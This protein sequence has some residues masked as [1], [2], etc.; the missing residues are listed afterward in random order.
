MHFSATKTAIFI[1]GASFF[2]LW[3]AS[4]SSRNAL[5]PIPSFA[6]SRRRETAIRDAR[7]IFRR[8]TPSGNDTTYWAISC[9]YPVSGIYT[10]F[11]RILFYVAM[12]FTFC[13]SVHEWLTASGMALIVTYSTTAA[14]HGVVLSFQQNVGTDLDYFAIQA[15]L[16][17]GVI[18]GAAFALF[19]PQSL[20]TDPKL[21]YKAWSVFLVTASLCMMVTYPK[22]AKQLGESAVMAACDVDWNCNDTCPLHGVP[23][24]NV[25][26][27][28]P[29]D[30][31]VP[32]SFGPW[33]MDDKTTINN[34]TIITSSSSVNIGTSIASTS[35]STF[36]HVVAISAGCALVL[37]TT[38]VNLEYPPRQ[39]RNR[40]VKLLTSKRTAKSCGFSR[41][42]FIAA[43]AIVAVLYIWKAIVWLV[44]PLV[45]VDFLFYMI[46]IWWD[47]KRTRRQWIFRNFPTRNE[48][49]KFRLRLA[50]GTSLA[51][52]VW[53]CTAYILWP[54]IFLSYVY[55]VEFCI[56]GIPESE[57]IQNVGQWGPWVSGG[58]AI[59]VACIN[60]L[61]WSA[62]RK[63]DPIYLDRGDPRIR[64][65]GRIRSWMSSKEW[66]VFL[67]EEWYISKKWLKDPLEVSWS[68]SDD[69]K[70]WSIMKTRPKGKGEEDGIC[71]LAWCK[72]DEEAEIGYQYSREK[73]ESGGMAAVHTCGWYLPEVVKKDEP[74][75]E[76][77]IVAEPKATDPWWA[78]NNNYEMEEEL[79]KEQ[80]EKIL[81]KERDLAEQLSKKKQIFC[82]K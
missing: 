60:K 33:I 17:P 72:Q 35:T 5:D 43:E 58:L 28:S 21:M 78:L 32:V 49:S 73:G 57:A 51:W 81:Q 42:R 75:E 29:L 52:Y 63:V 79:E 66:F 19:N 61:F 20:S 55:F 12:V 15:I 23:V 14:L 47:P 1:C 82:S 76:N 11:Q 44:W 22:F 70:E 3:Q 69:E 56:S 39:S 80:L 6:V 59:S 65:S 24:L 18:G 37:R 27:R 31:M 74:G 10:R 53:A 71:L 16:G 38:L 4:Q 34:T 36:N 46:I 77:A 8:D 2:V 67:A 9:A 26:F 41:E 25:L 45:T 50:I 48:P 64:K 54:I 68:S 30:N 13:A 40:I 7:E 62:R